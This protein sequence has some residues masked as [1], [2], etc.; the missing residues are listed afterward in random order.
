[1]VEGFALQP[2]FA[3]SPDMGAD[4]SVVF[5]DAHIYKKIKGFGKI[6]VGNNKVA[7]VC[8]KIQ[9]QMQ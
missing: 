5:K 2:D 1:M 3:D 6:F 7:G 4:R 9:V 8:M